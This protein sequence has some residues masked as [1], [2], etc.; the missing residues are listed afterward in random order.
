LFQV[1]DLSEIPPEG[2]LEWCLL[3]PCVTWRVLVAGGDG[4]VGWVLSAV[5]KLKLRVSTGLTAQISNC[6][7]W[8]NKVSS[9]TFNILFFFWKISRLLTFYASF[10]RTTLHKRGLYCH[11]VSVQLYVTLVDCIQSVEGIVKLLVRPGSTITPPLS[12]VGAEAPRAT[13]QTAT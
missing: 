1:I 11:L 13:E 12:S 4:T 5:D 3:L 2:A 6:K 10:Y 7:L 9:Q 8:H